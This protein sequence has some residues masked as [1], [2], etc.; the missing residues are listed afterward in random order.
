MSPGILGGA[1][2]RL[3]RVGHRNFGSGVTIPTYLAFASE[4]ELQLD[5]E[6]D[7]FIAATSGSSF[8]L[9]SS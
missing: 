4:Q 6:C 5:A 1:G 7:R 8:D 2:A 9:Q 3:C